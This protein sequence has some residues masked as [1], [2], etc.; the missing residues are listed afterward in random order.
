MTSSI[1][2]APATC[3]LA[4]PAGAVN[5]RPKVVGAADTLLYCERARG[6]RL[7]A[8]PVLLAGRILRQPPLSSPCG[9]GQARRTTVGRQSNNRPAQQD[10]HDLRSQNQQT[11][12]RQVA[13]RD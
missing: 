8:S 6:G 9:A 10:H 1:P 3:R 7:S 13:N 2:T 12:S 11:S 4:R 5:L